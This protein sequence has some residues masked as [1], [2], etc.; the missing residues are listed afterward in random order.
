MDILGVGE[1]GL[2]A[3]RVLETSNDLTAVVEVG[4]GD[5]RGVEGEIHPVE[6]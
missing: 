5:G 3:D 1:G 6:Q 4:V 2:A